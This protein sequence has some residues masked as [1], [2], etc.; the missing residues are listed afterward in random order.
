[1]PVAS[2]AVYDYPDHGSVGMTKEQ[3]KAAPDFH[4]ASET[5]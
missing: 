4:Y 3:L 2:N 5:K 1:M